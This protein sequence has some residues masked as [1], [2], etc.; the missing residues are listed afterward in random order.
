M[1]S[2]KKKKQISF[3][4][5]DNVSPIITAQIVYS[6]GIVKLCGIVTISCH[7]LAISVIRWKLIVKHTVVRI[8]S[9]WLLISNMCPCLFYLSLCRMV[10]SMVYVTVVKH[11]IYKV[12][13]SIIF[14]MRQIFAQLGAIKSN[15][16]DAKWFWLAQHTHPKQ[17]NY[18]TSVPQFLRRKGYSN[19]RHYKTTQ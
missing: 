12:Y 14:N 16:A 10:I 13:S 5:G 8:Y 3:S 6:C 18:F 7:L 1:V 11:D 15:F 2:T 4:G 19:A 9:R 17:A